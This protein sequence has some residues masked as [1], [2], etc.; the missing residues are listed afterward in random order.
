MLLSESVSGIVNA[1]LAY[2]VCVRTY[3]FFFFVSTVC[4]VRPVTYI[5]EI[6]ESSS[7]NYALL[8]NSDILTAL[9]ATVCSVGQPLTY[10]HLSSYFGLP[11]FVYPYSVKKATKIK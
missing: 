6:G 11:L 9:I 10:N 2:F 7:V 1:A 8:G 5:F 4:V 3:T